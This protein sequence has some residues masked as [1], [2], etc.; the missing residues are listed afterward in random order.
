MAKQAKIH[1]SFHEHLILNRWVLSLLGQGSFADLKSV[2]SDERLIG[3]NEDG[4]SRFFEAFQL[5]SLFPFSEK[6]SEEDVRRYDLN[7]VRHWQQ[8]TAKRNQDS[9]HPLQMKYFQYLSLLFTEIYLDWFF[10][11]QAEM[12]AGLN[13]TLANYQKEK[14]YLE[15]SDYQAADLNKIAFWNATGS[16]KTLL[17]HVNILQ[18][19]YYCPEKIDQI[20]LLTPNEG[21]S[22]QHLQEF[23]N[24]GFQATFF[25]KNNQSGDLLNSVQIIDINKLADKHGDK[26]VAVESLA[27][28]NLVLVDEGHRGTSGNRSTSGNR[29]TSGKTWFERREQL[30]G[31]GFAF[32]YSATFGQAVSKG[33]IVKEQIEEW[34]KDKAKLLFGKKSLK[35][36]DEYQLAQLQPDVLA[37]QEIRQ[38]AMLEVYAKAVL[39]DYSYKYFYA[40]GYGKESQ[41][42]N[43][44]DADYQ[45]HGDM[46]LTACLLVF[47][48]QLYL[49]EQ[50]QKAISSFQIEKPLWVFVGHTVNKSKSSNKESEDEKQEKSDILKILRFLAHFLND[51]AVI[52]N[53]LKQLLSDTAVL[54]NKDGAN[55]FAGQF[56]PLMSFLGKEADLY[57]DILQKVFN[58]A[59]D[60]RLQV[61]LLKGKEA[62]GELSLSVGNAAPFGVINIGDASSFA[63]TVATQTT[64]DVIQNEFASSL[65]RRINTA[66]SDI[67]LLIGSKKFTEGWSS[68]RVSTM[69]LLNMGK[70]EGSQIIQL[71]GRGVRLKGQG[72]SLKRSQAHERPK[73]VF[74]EKLE[75]LNIFGI[76]AGY[77][78]EFKKYL[79]EEGITPPDEML[80]VDFKVRPNLPNTKLKTVQLKDGYKDNQKMGFK[81]QE[82]GISF[83]SL[84]E[85]YLGKVK[86]LQVDLDMYPKIETA[87]TVGERTPLD[88]REKNTLDKALFA[89]FDWETIYLALW[90]Y[91]W[92][93]SW[94][95]VQLNKTVIQQ[96]AQTDGWYQLWI[97]KDR[98][99]IR[100]FAD[101]HYQQGILIELLKLYMQRF[102]QSLKGMYEGQYYE[103]VEVNSDYPAL[104]NGYQ[105]SIENHDDGREYAKKLSQ[106]K[107]VIESGQLKEVL[108]WQAANI[109]AICFEPHLYYPIMTLENAEALP[110]T[111]KPMDMNEASEIR[112]VQDLQA[113]YQDGSLKNWIGDKDFYLLRNAANKKKGLGF[114]LAGNFYPDFLLWLVDRET[115]KQWLS[116]IDPKGIL[117]MGINDPKFGLAE[118]VKNLQKENGLDIQL[119]AF[120]LSITKREDVLHVNVEDYGKKNILF[121]QDKDYLEV[122]FEK[123]LKSE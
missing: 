5:R 14:G 18:Y 9:G 72:Y 84:P 69:G 88:K 102:Y 1:R 49:F 37:L 61:A 77:M 106:L 95:N 66:D 58:T 43:L 4:Q 121:M 85:K 34:Q 27:G 74:L 116:F 25:N 24:S 99:T 29:G 17:M 7:I 86:R 104:Q 105:F 123:I 10:N 96:F 19:Q 107:D 50:H 67:Q 119:N 21:L 91:K 57:N 39:F 2:L 35:G 73:G 23:L 53:R 82:K 94:W 3:L 89:F 55:I 65:F 13:E 92:Q 22:H 60:G 44:R 16:G 70:S 33:K 36:L 112:F 15:L 6:I 120:I 118:E 117:Q 62:D 40:D 63:K 38:L 64:F 110:L 79:K 31:D 54:T 20:I 68:W 81:R 80:T 122:M 113:A 97:P 45:A 52:E 90:E 76:A 56:T 59:I 109:T 32:E 11:R 93:R 103:V 98:L 115:G 12:L 47:Y 78:E 111:M 41:I 8:I 114:A 28:Q 87:G 46:Y 51:R 71:F 30:I 100:T 48:Q 83:F 75:T 42:L 101:I 108:G 26:T